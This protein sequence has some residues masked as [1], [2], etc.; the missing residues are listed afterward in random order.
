MIR[1]G[2]MCVGK[3]D[4]KKKAKRDSLLVAAFALFTDK[5]VN[6]TSVSDI[7]KRANMAKGTFYLFFKDKIKRKI[8]DSY[9]CNKN[10]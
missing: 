7:V 1:N 6:D 9:E 2:G 5:G 10:F 3:L 8:S 4:E